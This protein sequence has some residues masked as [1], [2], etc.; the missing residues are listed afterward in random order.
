[1]KK[2]G[3]KNRN[4]KNIL[5][6]KPF[7]LK[8]VMITVSV[9][10]LQ[11]LVTTGYFV[12]TGTKF[13]NET[14][15]QLSTQLEIQEALKIVYYQL[16]I[17]F[18]GANIDCLIVGVVLSLYF[19]HKAA[20][21]NYAIKRAINNL[22]DGVED[23]R[24]TLRKGDEFHDL[25]ERINKMFDRMKKRCDECGKDSDPNCPDSNCPSKDQ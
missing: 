17:A 4:V 15:P 13:I 9:V 5:I 3:Q 16:L 1:M 10:I 19:S 14:L 22:I 6:D 18:T 21:P 7:Q 11:A 20:G 8:V 12:I 2:Q 25:A 24:I 23:H